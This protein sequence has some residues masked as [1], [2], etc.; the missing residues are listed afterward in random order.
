MTDWTVSIADAR[1]SVKV[2][3][4]TVRR[5]PGGS[6]RVEFTLDVSEQRVFDALGRAQVRGWPLELTAPAEPVRHVRV[7]KR[8]T[9]ASEVLPRGGTRP[10]AVRV[11]A[12]VVREPRA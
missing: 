7:L 1:T 8:P 2:S 4:V 5:D 11:L 10:T 9:V 12:R 6:D 3:D